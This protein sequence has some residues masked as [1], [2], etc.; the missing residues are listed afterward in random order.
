MKG[1]RGLF[2][3]FEGTEGSGKS[4]QM[5][6]LVE[7]LRETGFTV[8]EN[9][10]PGATSIGKQIRRILLDPA[11]QEM[12]P[13]TELLL[14]FASRAQAAAEIILPALELGH[15]VVSDRFTDSTLAYQGEA[16][17]LGFE[18]VLKAHRIALGSLLPD[19]T[20][21]IR[22]DVETG[23]AR[24]E[25]RNRRSPEDAM[26]ARLDRQSL[27]FHRRVCEGYEK[28]AALEPQR[29]HMVDGDGDRTT[30]AQRVWAEV[31]RVIDRKM[32]CT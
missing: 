1:H 30:V 25:N 14:M 18:T 5:Q 7:R 31:S 29:F 23:L 11:H 9:Q 15:I 28:I 21:C 27:D 8:I 22:I 4:T 12:A 6:L 26:E 20:I 17:G 3:T 16:R 19:L 24:A 13:M 10:E 2:L 32:S